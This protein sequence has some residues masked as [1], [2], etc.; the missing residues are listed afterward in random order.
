MARQKVIRQAYSL[1][2]KHLG[3]VN[4]KPLADGLKDLPVA[5][6]G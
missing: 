2:E 1:Y 6:L 5:R 3:E 4:F